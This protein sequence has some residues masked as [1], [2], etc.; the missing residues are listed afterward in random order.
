VVFIRV[1]GEYL[2]ASGGHDCRCTVT[3]ERAV[4]V[5]FA[6]IKLP[7]LTAS[8]LLSSC[9]P[10]HPVTEEQRKPLQFLFRFSMRGARTL[11]RHRLQ[12]PLGYGAEVHAFSKLNSWRRPYFFPSALSHRP[13]SWS[14]GYSVFTAIAPVSRS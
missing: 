7:W 10:C 8:V 2:A 14:L 9:D 12:Y 6:P 1:D 4:V 13:D 5:P 11:L 3:A